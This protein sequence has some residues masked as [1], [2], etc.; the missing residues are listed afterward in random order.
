MGLLLSLQIICDLSAIVNMLSAIVNMLSAIVN[1]LSAI[2]NML[3]A[4]VNMLSVIVNTLSAIVNM[5]SA[6]VNMYS[7][8]KVGVHVLLLYR[9]QFQLF[10]IVMVAKRPAYTNVH[11]KIPKI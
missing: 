4:I 1:M 7:M 9:F 10:N 5:L 11:D 3:S 8:E 2:V 6:I